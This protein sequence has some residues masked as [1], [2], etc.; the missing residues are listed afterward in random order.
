[1]I[2]LDIL[3]NALGLVV[4]MAVLRD[5]FHQLFHPGGTGHLSDALMW[6]VWRAFRA[7][8]RKK[9]ERLTFAGPTALIV[10]IASWVALMVV[11]W[12]LIYWPH[13]PE[14]FLL[15]TGLDPDLQGGFPDALYVSFVTL[16]TLGYGD[17]TPTNDLL[18][19]LAP[20][21]ALIGFGLLTAS[22][23]WVLSIYPAL[24]RSRSLAQEIA[25]LHDAEAEAAT[26]VTRLEADFVERTLQDLVSK[27]VSVRNDLMQFE[28]TYFFHGSAHRSGLSMMLP[29]LLRLAE[30][31]QREGHP[32]EVRMSAR[33]L[34]GAVDEL[35]TTVATRFLGMTPAST[36]EAIEA[37]ARDHLR[38]PLESARVDS[39]G[40]P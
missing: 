29:Y 7:I 21:E 2:A 31:G 9:E 35:A 38:T 33:M 20:V 28:I 8:S 26:D 32:E 12:A 10:I 27:L 15:S 6:T 36:E 13:L 17:V 19:I 24:S 11:G 1:M 4:A 37:Y 23:T 16:T 30:R 3:I 39:D 5:V 14:S 25:L 22:I 40:S 34:H 18:R